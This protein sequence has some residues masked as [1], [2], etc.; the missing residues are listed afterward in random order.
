M[1]V[2]GVPESM[3]TGE[4]TGVSVKVFSVGQVTLNSLIQPIQVSSVHTKKFQGWRRYVTPL[5]TPLYSHQGAGGS[6][7]DLQE[8]GVRW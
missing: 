8:D 2:C 5:V 4:W 3:L 1:W 6:T 7:Q